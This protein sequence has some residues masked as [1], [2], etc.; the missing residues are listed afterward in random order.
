[1]SGAA[2]G[3]E[4]QLINPKL[5]EGQGTHR[6]MPTWSCDGVDTRRTRLTKWWNVVETEKQ[7]KQ[8]EQ[9]PVA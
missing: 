9:M 8:S 1:V 7:E 2:F 6:Y 5:I 3:E 4:G